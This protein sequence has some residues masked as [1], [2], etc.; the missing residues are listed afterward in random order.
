MEK[1]QEGVGEGSRGL[2]EVEATRFSGGDGDGGL[3]K[4]RVTTKDA[5]QH[6]SWF[7]R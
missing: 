7:R 3:G 1:A 6:Q 2:R 4:L 5:S